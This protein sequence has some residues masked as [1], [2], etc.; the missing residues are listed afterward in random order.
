MSN[1]L[2]VLEN[3]SKQYRIGTLQERPDT[4]RDL[5][6]SWRSAEQGDV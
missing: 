3:I 4:L 1:Q 6:T 5:V 2:F